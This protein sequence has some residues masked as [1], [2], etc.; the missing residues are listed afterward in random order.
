[1]VPASPKE[2]FFIDLWIKNVFLCSP[3]VPAQIV[4]ALTLQPIF[5]W[6]SQLVVEQITSKYL[7]LICLG[8][9]LCFLELKGLWV[10]SLIHFFDGRCFHGTNN[11]SQCDISDFVQLVFVCFWSGGPGGCGVLHDGMDSSCA[12]P[13]QDV[14]VSSPGCARQFL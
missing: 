7:D 9:N 14:C 5:G 12:D 10:C 4:E 11:G 3:E 8:K 13:S 6:C 1:M 2:V